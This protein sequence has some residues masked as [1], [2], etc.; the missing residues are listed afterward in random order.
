LEMQVSRVCTR[1]EVVNISVLP[2]FGACKNDAIQLHICC[3][4]HCLC[5]QILRSSF[6]QTIVLDVFG[7]PTDHTAFISYNRTFLG[8]YLFPTYLYWSQLRVLYFKS[9]FWAEKA[10]IVAQLN[11]IIT[12][13][14]YTSIQSCR[15]VI[16]FDNLWLVILV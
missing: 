12:H 10:F 6:S 11:A 5:E 3:V 13:K 15:H 4:W 1:C 8:F 9:L 2:F 14:G 7:F 16:S